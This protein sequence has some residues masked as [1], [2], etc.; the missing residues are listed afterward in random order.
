MYSVLIPALVASLIV[1]VVCVPT[2]LVVEAVRMIV[3]RRERSSTS[4]AESDAPSEQP[5]S[6]LTRGVRPAQGGR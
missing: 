2:L 4:P 1:L 5:R 6:V 3:A